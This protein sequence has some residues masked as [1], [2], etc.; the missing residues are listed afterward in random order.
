[1][2]HWTLEELLGPIRNLREEVRRKALMR[3]EYEGL[4]SASARNRP[5]I[6]PDVAAY[7]MERYAY[8]VCHKC[9]KVKFILFELQF[10]VLFRKL[11]RGSYAST[12]DMSSVPPS[13]RKQLSIANSEKIGGPIAEFKIGMNLCDYQGLMPVAGRPILI[14]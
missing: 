8:Y 7:A 4:T 5:G 6:I 10:F 2:S 13:N 1:M 12:L 9:G 14:S 3:L 11:L